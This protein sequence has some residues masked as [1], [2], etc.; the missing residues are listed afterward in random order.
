MI[1]IVSRYGENVRRGP[2]MSPTWVGGIA[3]ADQLVGIELFGIYAFS[4]ENFE[5]SIGVKPVFLAS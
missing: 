3:S 2:N 4:S 5:G 1:I